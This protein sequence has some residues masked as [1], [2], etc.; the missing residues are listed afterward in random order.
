MD[1]N[2]SF[3]TAVQSQGAAAVSSIRSLTS[4]KSRTR[5]QHNSAAEYERDM[6][7]R[8][9]S[10]CTSTK[11]AP[12]ELEKKGRNRDAIEK[13]DE[14]AQVSSI[15]VNEFTGFLGRLESMVSSTT[16]KATESPS[17][18]RHRTQSELDQRLSTLLSQ[19]KQLSGLTGV[20]E[21]LADNQA[22][23]DSILAER[24]A[25]RYSLS[26]VRTRL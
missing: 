25:L 9:T 21:M 4:T 22:E 17:K 24:R 26:S 5:G 13:I 3:N 19:K 11:Y 12:G 23:I 18:K 15:Q 1:S 14:L 7:S 8:A 2:S 20:E 6:A 10:G 16:T